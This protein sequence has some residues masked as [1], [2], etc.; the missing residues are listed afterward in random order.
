MVFLAPMG[1]GQY[2]APQNYKPCM[3]AVADPGFITNSSPYACKSSRGKKLPISA[4][5]VEERTVLIIL[6]GGGGGG[7]SIIKR[8]AWLH[9]LDLIVVSTYSRAITTAMGTLK[10]SGLLIQHLVLSL[11]PRW[12]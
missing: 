12:F 2:R 9:N 1:H 6:G 4:A 7:L 11:A 3:R 10:S 8:Q 5:T